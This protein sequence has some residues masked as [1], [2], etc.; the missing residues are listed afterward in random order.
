VGGVF[1]RLK[2]RVMKQENVCGGVLLAAEARLSHE[3]RLV[4]GAVVGLGKQ[5]VW[6]SS[7]T[8]NLTR[9]GN[10]PA[11]TDEWELLAGLKEVVSQQRKTWK[12]ARYAVV[13]QRVLVQGEVDAACLD[14][15]DGCE[16]EADDNEDCW[17][18]GVCGFSVRYGSLRGQGAAF[19]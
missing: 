18:D 17:P 8:M 16:V 10:L 2:N 19:L 12:G 15:G 3:L 4:L 7:D 5:G 9:L 1:L 13:I 11:L 6:Y 14:E